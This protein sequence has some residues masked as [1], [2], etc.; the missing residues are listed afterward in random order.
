MPEPMSSTTLRIPSDLWEM[1][2]ARAR[3]ESTSANAIVM[4]II[5]DHFADNAFEEWME[6]FH[7]LQ[8]HVGILEHRLQLLERGPNRLKSEG[9]R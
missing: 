2:K 5:R 7:Q 9:G 8:T 4:S 6:E 1:V 3:A